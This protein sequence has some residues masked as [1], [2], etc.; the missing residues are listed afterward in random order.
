ML[1]YVCSKILYTERGNFGE[2]LISEYEYP[3]YCNWK[4]DLKERNK[5]KRK[6]TQKH[7]EFC[8]SLFKVGIALARKS[9]RDILARFAFHIWKL[10]GLTLNLSFTENSWNFSLSRSVR[11]NQ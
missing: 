2:L 11:E 4:T 10:L 5:L 9:V 7:S 8:T 6:T 3:L 1:I